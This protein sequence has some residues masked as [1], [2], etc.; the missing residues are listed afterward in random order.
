MQNTLSL[1]DLEIDEEM[2][3]ADLLEELKYYVDTF[4]DIPLS[5]VMELEKY[6]VDIDEAIM[7]IEINEKGGIN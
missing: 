3:L 6:G 1:D 5:L 4:E 7:S 2:H